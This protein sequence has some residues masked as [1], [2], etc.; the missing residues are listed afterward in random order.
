MNTCIQQL[1]F[2]HFRRPAMAW[3]LTVLLALGGCT[4]PAEEASRYYQNG[5]DLLEQGD[6]AKAALQFRNALQ[7]VNTMTP[8]TYGL[9]LVAEQQEDWPAMIGL[10][11]QVV[12]AEATHWQAH[13]KR[14]QLLLAGGNAEAALEASDAALT[15]APRTPSVLALRAAVLF[16]MGDVAEAEQ[17]ALLALKQNPGHVETLL[18]LATEHLENGQ[19]LDALAYLNQGLEFS[20]G[21]VGLTLLKVQALERDGSAQEAQKLH[22]ALVTAQ[23]DVR[24]LKLVLAR[25]YI[26]NGRIAEAELT[27][28]TLANSEP[29]DL[30]SKLELVQLIGQTRGP[31]EATAELRALT[32]AYPENSELQFALVELLRGTRKNGDAD[33]LLGEMIQAQ[34]D[35]PES[36]RTKEALATSHYTQGRRA[37]AMMLVAQV[38]DTEPRSEQSLFLRATVAIEQRQ[39]DRAIADLRLLLAD[40]PASDRALLLL[41]V[42]YRLSGAFELAENQYQRAFL[43]NPTAPFG[44]AFA[45]YLIEKK[46]LVRAERV[47]ERSLRASPENDEILLKLAQVKLDQADWQG[48]EEVAMALQEKGARRALS[49]QIRGAI[50]AHGQDYPA[51][52]EAYQRAYEESPGQ[53]QIL[54]ALVQVH[55]AAGQWEEAVSLLESAVE[56]GSSGIVPEVLLGQVLG[57]TGAEPE[58]I[59]AFES[60]IRKDRANPAGY[61]GL[62]S[63]HLQKNRAA[64]AEKVV[65]AGLEASPG[66]SRLRVAKAAVLQR[67]GQV[68]AA[69]EHYEQLLKEN[70]NSDVIANNLASLLTERSDEESLERAYQLALRFERS[71]VAHFKD[72]LGWACYRLGRYAEAVTLLEEAAAQDARQAVFHYHLG[73]SYFALKD[74]SS[75]RRALELALEI[76]EHSDFP[77]QAEARA[78]LAQIAA[79]GERD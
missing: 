59:L 45:N 71:T 30:E 17:V 66:E 27:L 35:A 77:Q 21:H 58:A 67:N 42:A 38:L 60:A 26:R 28:K 76:G 31:D 48:A 10:L 18:I 4:P 3:W 19:T 61:L 12:A 33:R 20:P 2:N 69:I 46:D 53:P 36:L 34:G 68:D 40:K 1:R 9:A 5:M 56:S 63:L 24:A 79:L 32:K 13:L 54:R 74:A 62:A 65:D 29:G 7:I 37:D 15:L 41:A 73:M 51:S 64:E 11:N 72:T 22:E 57:L 39:L 50:S 47:L 16:R 70:P 52:L 43:A 78:A 14:G 23:P 8:A 75:A 25:F 49:E 6:S 55:I 44:I